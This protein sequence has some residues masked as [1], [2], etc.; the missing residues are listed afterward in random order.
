MTPAQAQSMGIPYPSGERIPVVDGDVSNCERLAGD[1]PARR[2]CWVAFDKK[3]MEQVVPWIPYLWSNNITITTPGLTRYVY[4]Q[5]SSYI[6]LTQIA[7]S[8]KV[9]AST[10]R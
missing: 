10:L 2:T 6:S 3:L 9:D 8:N 7:V 1:D 5:S 4:D